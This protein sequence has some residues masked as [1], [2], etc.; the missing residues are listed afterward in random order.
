MQAV[1]ENEIDEQGAA[2]KAQQ[3]ARQRKKREQ[4]KLDAAL[5]N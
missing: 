5:L 3:A 1:V 2:N 4:A